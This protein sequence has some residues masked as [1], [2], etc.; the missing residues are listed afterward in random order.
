MS[1]NH[2]KK[3]LVSN[4]THA[5]NSLKNKIASDLGLP[6]FSIESMAEGDEYDAEFGSELGAEWA[7]EKFHNAK[8]DERWAYLTARE[9]GSV[10]G[11]MTAHLIASAQ[12]A[13]RV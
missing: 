8:K 4:S 1:R 11:Q 6:G 10:G 9:A 12:S 13:L 3:Y 2:H 7:T 5:M